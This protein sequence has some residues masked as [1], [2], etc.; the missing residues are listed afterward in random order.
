MAKN[1]LKMCRIKKK[2]TLTKLATKSNIPTPVISMIEAGLVIPGKRVQTLLARAL[3]M[4][5]WQVFPEEIVPERLKSRQ[6]LC[7][8]K[9]TR[10]GV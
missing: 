9:D 6:G 5:L 10:Q 3:K 7:K 2:I 8:A 1:Y 4:D